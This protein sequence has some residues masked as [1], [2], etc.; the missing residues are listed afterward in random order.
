MKS[1]KEYLNSHGNEVDCTD[2]QS[3]VTPLMTA[4]F[5]GHLNVVKL[6]V[7]YGA[8]VNLKCSG[9]NQ[10]GMK[11]SDVTP[12]Y[13]AAQEGYGEIIGY[14]V[15]KGADINV[16]CSPLGFTPLY[17]AVFRGHYDLV[18]SLV[19]DFGAT[20]NVPNRCGDDS[21][22]IAVKRRAH[23]ILDTLIS[24]KGANCS[25]P[26]SSEKVTPLHWAAYDGDLRS[27]EALHTIGK[28]NLNAELIG[29]FTPL[30]LA[31]QQNHK[32]VT[33]FL[34][35]LGAQRKVRNGKWFPFMDCLD[36]GL[37][38]LAAAISR[39]V[40]INAMHFTG[41]TALH[42]NVGL[43]NWEASDFL[44]RKDPNS[45]AGSE[46]GDM[47][48]IMF[49][50][51]FSGHKLDV[52]KA[53]VDG[54]A[55]VN[56]RVRTQRGELSVL[57]AIAIENDGF[58]ESLLKI[59]IEAGALIDADVKLVDSIVIGNYSRPIEVTRTTLHA[60]KSSRNKI[61]ISMLMNTLEL[62]KA[63]RKNNLELAKEFIARGG[64]VNCCS[65]KF[66]TPLIY[67]SWKGHLDMVK[68]LL[69]HGASL[70]LQSVK[71][72]SPLH[73]AAKFNNKSIVIELLRAGAKHDAF[74]CDKTAFQ[75]AEEGGHVEI[76]SLL[77]FAAK[78]F[79]SGGTLHA[80]PNSSADPDFK[81]LLEANDEVPE[82]DLC[83]LFGRVL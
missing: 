56:A 48:V 23:E 60:I 29:G 80:C 28:A 24:A 46:C 50:C 39:G 35:K 65:V 4:C 17:L 38:P 1:I 30:D 9:I 7:S 74:C 57:P 40:D 10:F 2:P 21:I 45:R 51:I 62:F 61:A 55:D 5:Y 58:N 3:G 52:I 43:S 18:V 16:K 69:K 66:E 67:A 70:T 37:L 71:K 13:L 22:L 36:R 34:R 14:L 26:N 73:Y 53:L 63:I 11:Y 59:F 81:S 44:L 15:E 79:A 41:G 20:V 64:L 77:K 54:G 25:L 83:A 19:N 32:E 72:S 68:L 76:A 47:P 49:A 12:A 33:D 42:F 8:N 82:E 75:L 78:W 6:L 31:I 27:V